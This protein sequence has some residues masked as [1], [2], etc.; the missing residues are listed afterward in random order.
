MNYGGVKKR[1]GISHCAIGHTENTVVC[2]HYRI[3]Y[4]SPEPNVCA[5]AAAIK[6]AAAKKT[7]HGYNLGKMGA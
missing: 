3:S 5:T 2:P 6:I 1:F 7:G 4:R